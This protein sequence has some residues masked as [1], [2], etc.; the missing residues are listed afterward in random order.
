MPEGSHQT[1]FARLQQRLRQRLQTRQVV[2][3]LITGC[4]TSLLDLLL[5]SLLTLFLRVPGVF[6]N[7]ASTAITVCVS[8]LINRAF[9]FHVEKATWRVF[10]LFAGLTLFTGLVLQ[11]AIIWGLVQ[12]LEP[13]AL[14]LSEVLALPLI[15]I[16][17]MLVGAICNYLGYR[18]IFQEKT[19]L[20]PVQ[21]SSGG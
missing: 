16:C 14:P 19:V 17:A 3:Y 11:S 8:Y 15:K 6:A 9:V 10:F 18:L 5:F 12:I 4:G 21:N 2:R 1:G 20:E 13:A 7:I